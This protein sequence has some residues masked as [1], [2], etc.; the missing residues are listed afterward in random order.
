[1]GPHGL[2][3]GK[4][5]Y[6]LVRME[7]LGSP[8][9]NLQ[10]IPPWKDSKKLFLD[11]GKTKGM[12][13]SIGSKEPGDPTVICEGWATGASIHEATGWYVAAAMSASNVLRVAQAF[14]RTFP[15]RTLIIAGDRDG[16][17][18]GQEAAQQSADAVGGVMVLPEFGAD[19]PDD[20]SDFNDLAGLRGPQ[21]VQHQIERAL[22]QHHQHGESKRKDMSMQASAH[23]IGAREPYAEQAG[24]VNG[25]PSS[26]EPQQT[27]APTPG[28]VELDELAQL[29]PFEYEKRRI[30]EAKRLRVRVTALDK[31]IQSRRAAAKDETLPGQAFE[32]PDIEPWEEPVTGAEV[33]EELVS[34]IRRHV[35]LSPHVAH[36]VALWIVWSWLIDKFDVAPRLV[37][38]SPEKRCGKSTLLE[39]IHVLVPRALMASNI[40]PAAIFRTIEAAS[41]TLLIDEADT[42]APNNEELRGILNSG[43]TRTG[44]S[45]VRCVG[46]DHRPRR[47]STWCPMALAAIGSLPSTVEDRSILVSM[48]RKASGDTVAP[49]PRGGRKAAA[50][51]S[52]LHLLARRIR[53]WTDDYGDELADRE[54]P[55]PEDLHD[56]A[57]DNWRPLL[58]I[59]DCVGGAWSTKARDAAVMLSRGEVGADES[60]GIQLLED[61]WR[62]AESTPWERLTSKALCS[63]LAALE[64]RP[65]ADWRFGRP[66]TPVQLARLLKPYKIKS[67]TLR[68]ADGHVAKGY[69]LKDF[70]DAFARYL[71]KRYTV[72]SRSQSDEEPLLRNVTRPPCNGSESGTNPAPGADCNG[73]TFQ[74]PESPLEEREQAPTRTNEEVIDL[75]SSS[76]E[77]ELF[78]PEEE[79]C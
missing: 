45:I 74:K 6:L 2:R 29:H 71:S 60:E 44:A 39:V 40:T 13:A 37:L 31:E 68:C 47:F 69:F 4:D 5:G 30:D 20:L 19:A 15:E 55:V 61:V 78:P 36:A 18:R 43:H 63:D 27:N 49:F 42:F 48:Q 73:V 7:E 64:E 9:L 46:E 52:E 34:L 51:K 10:R 76:G 24:S 58:A 35:S 26:A 14:R 72:T 38:L 75:I 12:F 67:Q 23:H 54:P 50:L 65:W 8:L 79:P 22:Q 59:A 56:R 62:L 17:G 3:V 1:M 57:A 25:A 28:G 41:P 53:R 70:A 32:F 66:L 16:S 21:A 11:G 77:S 33:L